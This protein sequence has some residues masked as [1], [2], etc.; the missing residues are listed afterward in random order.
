MHL[1]GA[2]CV[3]STLP[4]WLLLSGLP[5]GGQYYHFPFID[6]ELGSGRPSYLPDPTPSEGWGWC[7]VSVGLDLG[8][9]LW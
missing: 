5:P 6:K 9:L 2:S 3:P 8:P 1:L 7:L 4:G